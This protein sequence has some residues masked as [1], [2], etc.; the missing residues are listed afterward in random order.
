MNVSLHEHMYVQMSYSVSAGRATRRLRRRYH[1]LAV[2]LDG[3]ARLAAAATRLR[4]RA[5]GPALA[6]QGTTDPVFAWRTGCGTGGPAQTPGPDASGTGM[7]AGDAL[8]AGDALGEGADVGTGVG[9]GVGLGSPINP[10]VRPGMRPGV[11]VAVRV[12]LAAGLDTANLG[13]SLGVAGVGAGVDT[14]GVGA[15]AGVAAGASARASGGVIETAARGADT[16]SGEGAVNGPV[17]L[18]T[19]LDARFGQGGVGSGAGRGRRGVG[20][21]APAPGPAPAP[22]PTRP[23]KAR[24]DGRGDC[25]PMRTSTSPRASTY[26]VATAVGGAEGACLANAVASGRGRGDSDMRA[27]VCSRGSRS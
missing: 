16:C 7:G 24:V 25:T 6:L 14:A 10:G 20:V 3:K 13:A 18:T 2:A 12:A 11:G 26:R 23:S 5:G 27:A 4:L 17:T 9:T 8:D 22:R 21:L 1:C 15:G 19:V